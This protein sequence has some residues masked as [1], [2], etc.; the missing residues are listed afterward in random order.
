MAIPLAPDLNEKGTPVIGVPSD[1]RVWVLLAPKLEGAV[2]AGLMLPMGRN[3]GS[4]EALDSHARS[5]SL[6]PMGTNL[7]LV[8]R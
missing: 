5:P 1:M 7:A 2:P 8:Q 3:G 4:D 6:A